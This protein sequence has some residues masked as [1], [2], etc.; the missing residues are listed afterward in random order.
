MKSPSEIVQLMMQ[1]DA[2]SQ[3]L[4]VQVLFVEEGKCS[5]K[6]TVKSE[7]LNGFHIAHGGISYSLADSSLAFA[8]NSH[9]QHCVSVE[10][11]ISHL[12]KVSLGDELTSV[13]KEIYRGKKTGV[14]EVDIFNQNQR[15]IAHFKGTVFVG[16]KEW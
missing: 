2:F 10:T 6:I 16:E 14:Y 8:A 15:L 9:G 13:A 5:L 12:G 3:W 1:N 11:S 7:M 4:G